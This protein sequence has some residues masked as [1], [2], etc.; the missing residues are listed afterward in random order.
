[1]NERYGWQQL[2]A[3]RK[4][5]FRYKKNSLLLPDM[6]GGTQ[7]TIL[8]EKFNFAARLC[9]SALVYFFT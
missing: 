6:K 9:G 7:K 5:W 3:A 1:M 8:F 4:K 2:F